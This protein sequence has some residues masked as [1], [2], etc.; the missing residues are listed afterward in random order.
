MKNRTRARISIEAAVAKIRG[1]VVGQRRWQPQRERQQQRQSDSFGPLRFQLFPF[2]V[3]KVSEQLTQLSQ[4]LTEAATELRNNL[5][6]EFANLK[7]EYRQEL[8]E[9][10][11]Q[12]KFDLA[13]DRK[14]QKE[15]LHNM[16]LQNQEKLQRSRQAML[17]EMSQLTRSY[18]EIGNSTRNL[19]LDYTIFRNAQVVPAKSTQFSQE[20]FLP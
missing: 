4:N 6:E 7:Q 16:N 1:W 5:R 10:K 2:L 12:H 20:I 3:E 13:N 18:A 14:E 9:A 17:S 19:Q 15:I 8:N 11:T